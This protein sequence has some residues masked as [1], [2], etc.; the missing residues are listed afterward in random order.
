M[1]RGLAIQSFVLQ[2]LVLQSFVFRSLVPKRA[3][4]MLE[5]QLFVFLWVHRLSDRFSHDLVVSHVSYLLRIDVEAL[6]V[7]GDGC[8]RLMREKIKALAVLITGIQ[9]YQAGASE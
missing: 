7:L 3:Y 2:S 4:L 6:E 1:F 8:S 9:V 5:S